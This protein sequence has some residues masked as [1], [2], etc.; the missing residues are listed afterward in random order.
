MRRR[1]LLS[2][3]FIFT[4]SI[5]STVFVL[6]ALTSPRWAVQKYYLNLDGQSSLGAEWVTPICIAHKSPFYRCESPVINT[7]DPTHP[8]CTVP[9]CQFYKPYGRNQTSCRLAVETNDT[10]PNSVTNAGEQECQEVHW[11]GNLQ[12]AASVFITLGLILLLPLT[13]ANAML[14]LGSSS[15]SSSPEPRTEAEATATSTTI[16]ENHMNS[17]HHHPASPRHLLSPF[18]PSLVLLTIVFFGVGALLQF[19]AQF[20]GVLAMTINGTPFPD[21]A[22]QHN[23]DILGAT[24]WIMDRALTSY[25]SVAWT[26]ALCAAVGIGLVYRLPRLEKLL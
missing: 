6:L 1:V 23:R 8:V 26:M 22:V 19:T 18:A 2:S 5:I 10:D 25:A 7:T 15:S 3:L 21:Q 16:K 13:V 4:P 24:P 9:N 12:I 14:A 11:T 20:F 17:N